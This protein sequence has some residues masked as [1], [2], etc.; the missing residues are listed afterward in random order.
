[1]TMETT[2]TYE[3]LSPSE[4]PQALLP[5]PAPVV[6]PAPQN[7]VAAIPGVLGQLAGL[8]EVERLNFQA[9]EAIL[10]LGWQSVLDMG[11]ALAQIR[12]ERLYRDEFGTFEDYCRRKWEYSRRQV[13]RWISA[14][15]VVARLRPNWSHRLPNN[16]SQLRPLVSLTPEQAESVW[17]RV[18]ERAVARR[19]SAHLVRRVLKE[20]RLIQDTP[21]A[22][23]ASRPS[24]AEQR[25]VI[26][27]AIGE[28]LMLVSQNARR[29]LL[30]EKLEALH[31]HIQAAF[32]SSC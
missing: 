10:A 3:T 23:G 20:S 12:D 6:P 4:S 16:E 14:A 13:D 25:R 26:G 8:S 2:D 17:K 9:C 29:E 27:Q 21:K 30:T 31:R 19:I 15:Q 11:Q 18:T 1:L 32:G 5:V 24:M 22:A 28:L 7:V